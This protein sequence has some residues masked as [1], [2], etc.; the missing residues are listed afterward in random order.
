MV[1]FIR[2]DKNETLVDLDVYIKLDEIEYVELS[3][4][5]NIKNYSKFLLDNIDKQDM[6]IQTFEDLSELR[7]W[8]WEVYFMNRQNTGDEYDNVTKQIKEIF[9]TVCNTFP[10]L[11]IVKD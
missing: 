4:L 10:T 6:I 1:M 8:L 2:N 7:G 3:V 5:I 9:K 11:H